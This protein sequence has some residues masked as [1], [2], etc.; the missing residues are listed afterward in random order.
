MRV[1][2]LEDQ[3]AEM[4]PHMTLP[5]RDAFNE[6]I[7]ATR[8]A[9]NAESEAT[10]EMEEAERRLMLAAIVEWSYGVVSME[11]L[12]NDV[13]L[14]DQEKLG[15]AAVKVVLQSPLVKR[16]LQSSEASGA[17]GSSRRSSGASRSRR[18]SPSPT[19]AQ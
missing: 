4:R 17:N 5:M 13:P 9:P 16:A 6:C 8:A 2:L 18:S 14:E 3:W 15:L 12:V 1:D 19:S 7:T 10:P 11:T